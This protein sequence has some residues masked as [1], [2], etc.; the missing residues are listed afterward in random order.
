[1]GPAGPYVEGMRIRP[2][3]G[4]LAILLVLLTFSFR[5]RADTE[6]EDDNELRED[7]LLCE[8]A[9]AHVSSCCGFSPTTS[10]CRYYHYEWYES[11]GCSG[12]TGGFVRRDIWPSVTKEVAR[13]MTA[14]SCDA[15]RE[16]ASCAAWIQDL[17]EANEK[18]DSRASRCGY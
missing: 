11:C 13:T 8:E 9:L 12:G 10:A 15:I 5:A 17:T 7:V 2:G 1:M 18:S 4:A 3:N 16:G 14:T 6:E